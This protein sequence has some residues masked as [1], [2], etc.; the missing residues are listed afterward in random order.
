MS[1]QCQTR[2]VQ[3]HSARD[4]NCVRAIILRAAWGACTLGASTCKQEYDLAI[5]DYSQAIKYQPDSDT[6]Y[7]YRARVQGERRLRVRVT[8]EAGFVQHE[9][10]GWLDNISIYPFSSISSYPD[11]TDQIH[12]IQVDIGA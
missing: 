3:S 7:W 4:K 10:S 8:D 5:A 2:L 12:S 11:G 9:P 6:A 1:R